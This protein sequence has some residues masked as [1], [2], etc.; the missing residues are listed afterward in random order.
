[1]VQPRVLNNIIQG[2][3]GPCFWIG[4][5]EDEPVDPGQDDGPGAHGAGLQ[6]HVKGATAEPPGFQMFCGGPEG[7]DLSVGGGIIQAFRPV[8]APGDDLFL[9]DQDRADRD[10]H[11]PGCLPG[12]GQGLAH[13]LFIVPQNKPPMTIFLIQGA[14]IMIQLT[15]IYSKFIINTAA[16]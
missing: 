8:I 7:D 9:M 11:G 14:Y 12:L 1:M 10:F 2:P 4:G 15:T 5:A 16:Y 13:P 3:A 6:G